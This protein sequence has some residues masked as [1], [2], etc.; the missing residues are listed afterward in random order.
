MTEVLGEVTRNEADHR[1][2]IR[3][4]GELA[5]FAAYETTP[6]LVVLTHTEIGPAWEGRGVGGRL[7]RAALDDV[8][9]RDLAVLPI[10]PFVQG[11]INRHPEYAA[12]D[13]RRR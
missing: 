2:E 4:D 13:Y 11:W 7:V 10:C 6:E 9:G 5:G 3:V 12:L 1:Y 8:R